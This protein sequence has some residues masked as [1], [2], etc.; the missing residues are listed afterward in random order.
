M[1]VDDYN[2]TTNFFYSDVHKIGGLRQVPQG[3][4]IAILVV[5]I[6][7]YL[8][9]NIS[10][11]RAIGTPAGSLP[12]DREWDIQSEVIDACKSKGQPTADL[13]DDFKREPLPKA[14][15]SA[16]NA[17]RRLEKAS[18]EKYFAMNMLAVDVEYSLFSN[19]GNPCVAV[20]GVEENLALKFHKKFQ[21]ICK[22][23][24]SK[25][26]IPEALSLL[27]ISEQENLYDDLNKPAS[28]K[29]PVTEELK[30]NNYVSKEDVDDETEQEYS[31]ADSLVSKNL[32]HS[33]MKLPCNRKD[34]FPIFQKTYEVK[35]D[36]NPRICIRC[37]KSKPDRCHH[38]SICNQCIRRMDHHCPWLNNCIGLNNY[39]FFFNTIFY[40]AIS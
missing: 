27:P 37:L 10:L 25:S 23:K 1:A 40:C 22:I 6:F 19:R 31:E 11:A 3:I 15:K 13:L 26:V 34:I 35:I 4:R 29:Q 36:G 38:C 30:D 28:S 18:Q 14:L 39:K 9:V 7:L 24:T 16:K 20:K 33:D 17:V 8:I 5:A 12:L 21:E 32:D 2:K